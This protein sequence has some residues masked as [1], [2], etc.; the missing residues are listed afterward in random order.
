MYKEIIMIENINKLLEN[1]DVMCRIGTSWYR[2]DE[3]FLVDGKMPIFV[4]DDDGGEHEFDMADIDEFDPIFEGF[5]E[6]DW[7]N[8]GVA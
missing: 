1:N 4:S 7:T 8:V 3:I 6:M 2:L 5:K